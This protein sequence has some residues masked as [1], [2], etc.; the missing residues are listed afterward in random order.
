M[1]I[2]HLHI[3]CY[4]PSHSSRFQEAS[5]VS[6]DPVSVVSKASV[7]VLLVLENLKVQRQT[8]CLY[9]FH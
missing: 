6:V 8:W 7:L 9:Q 1:F 4:L 5:G 3:K 2:S